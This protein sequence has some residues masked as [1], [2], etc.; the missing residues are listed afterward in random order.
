[1]HQQYNKEE[2]HNIDIRRNNV[3]LCFLK[4]GEDSSIIENPIKDMNSKNILVEVNNPI[5]I[6]VGGKNV[7]KDFEKLK[8]I[9]KLPG[10]N[11]NDIIR[12]IHSKLLTIDA[13]LNERG[14][15]FDEIIY[16][17][18]GKINRVT[19]TTCLDILIFGGSRSG[20]STFI[21]NLSNSL[22]AR[23]QNNAETCTTKCTEYIIPFENLDNNTLENHHG[24]INNADLE[25][26]VLELI[27][28][29]PGK[30]KII[31]TP[32]LFDDTD[33][34]KV[35]K[36]LENY[37]SEEIEII[38]LA[39]FFMKDTTS[40][41]K[42]KDVIKILIKYDIPVFFVETHCKKDENI[43][44]ED[45]IF[46]KDIKSFIY[47]NFEENAGNLLL[48]K[49]KYEIYNI[50]RINQKKD[51]EH[52]SIFGVDILIEKI[53]HFF[54]YKN[55]DELIENT[56]KDEQNFFQQ[57][58]ILVSLLSDLTSNYKNF[59]LH[60]LL[61]RKFLTLADVS[62]Y[63]YQKSISL[64]TAATFLSSASCLIP[65]PFVDL[66][67]YYTIHIG[68]IMGI[69]SVFGIKMDEVNVNIIMRTNGTNLGGNYLSEW[70]VKQI[71]HT[72]IKIALNLG[73]F[74]SDAVVFIPFL[75]FVAKGPDITFSSIDTVVLGRNLVK[76]CNRLPRNQQ[77]FRN[78]LK[79]FNYILKKLD[80]IRLRIKNEN[81]N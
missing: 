11:K 31:D 46:Y 1:M 41:N 48:Y 67:I 74:A 62:N 8:F 63:F 68:M 4:E 2:S 42:S 56:L 77:F 7:D 33:V 60:D 17:N 16:R 27:N 38:Q 12:N 13:Y 23:E 64:V 28:Q 10:G 44:L 61:F 22:L 52:N 58:N 72:G 55:L 29:N 76:T 30:L 80:E 40:L 3:I 14:N 78:E 49:G 50:I 66:P 79:K 53:L 51:V 9:N 47:N 69:L 26:R 54:L 34:S 70:T 43:K 5:I 15:I 32:G 71:V 59:S 18:L 35:C 37:I 25:N 81:N 6:T 57:K 39:L 21:N 45:S 36:C 65:I 73:K 75:G 24:E 19:A 20:K